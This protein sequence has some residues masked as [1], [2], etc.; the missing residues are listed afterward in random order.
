MVESILDASEFT[1]RITSRAYQKEDD[2]VGCGAVK[3][4]ENKTGPAKRQ[5]G[6]GEIFI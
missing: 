3:N 6:G 1:A 4:S 5:G 2:A